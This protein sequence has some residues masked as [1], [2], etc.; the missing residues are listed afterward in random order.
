MKTREENKAE[1]STSK[2]GTIKPSISV[3]IECIHVLIAIA[4]FIMIIIQM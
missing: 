1:V 3:I 4:T 2:K